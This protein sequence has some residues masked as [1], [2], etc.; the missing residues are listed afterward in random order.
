M[1]PSELI[2][3]LQNHHQLLVANA[4]SR[5]SPDPTQLSSPIKVG[6][7]PGSS[8]ESASL[9]STTLFSSSMVLVEEGDGGGEP[10]AAAEAATRDLLAK[11]PGASVPGNPLQG[12]AGGG[13][14]AAAAAAV[15]EA[16]AQ[17]CE[18]ALSAAFEAWDGPGAAQRRGPL[19]ELASVGALPPGPATLE[20]WCRL[21]GADK[22]ATGG[23]SLADLCLEADGPGGVPAG[24]QGTSGGPPP[25][26]AA[27]AVPPLVVDSSTRHRIRKDLRRTCCNP[28]FAEVIDPDPEHGDLYRLLVAYAALDPAVGYVQGMNFIAALCLSCAQGEGGEDPAAAAASVSASAPA[29]DAGALAGAV[30]G[31]RWPPGPGSALRGVALSHRAPPSAPAEDFARARAAV[32]R[33]GAEAAFLLFTRLMQVRACARE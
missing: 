14:D 32:G 9:G 28:L 3:V 23:R 29:A 24:D 11:L 10:M 2:D 21:A 26:D 8:T 18:G 12:D 25:G 19:A 4:V 17:A 15:A 13:G 30:G 22:A 33:R 31:T 7:A 27:A 6:Q 20:A 16:A 1:K 5:L